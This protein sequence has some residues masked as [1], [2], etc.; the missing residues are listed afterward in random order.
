[1]GSLLVFLLQPPIIGYLIGLAWNEAEADKRTYFMMTLSAIYLGCMNA[2]PLIVRERSIY[3]R[4]RMTGLNLWSYL[5]SKLQM[6]SLISL[7]QCLL[8]LVVAN[9][10]VQFYEGILRHGFVLIVLTLTSIA[11]SGLGLAISAFAR[12]TYMAVIIVPLLILP[13]ILFSEVV[14]GGRFDNDLL[15]SIGKCT[16]TKWS[17]DA[18]IAATLEWEWDTLLG[19]PLV[20]LLMLGIFLLLAAAKLKMDDVS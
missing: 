17:Y 6:L 8:L 11:A 16:I 1:M 15:S 4:E 9:R 13:Q 10:W 19:S 3:N 7:I 5:L 14:L 20:L 2:C 18:L 12:T